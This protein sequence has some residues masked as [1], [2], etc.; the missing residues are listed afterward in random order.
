CFLG[1]GCFEGKSFKTWYLQFFAMMSFTST[2]QILGNNEAI[3]ACTSN[4]YS[5]RV[6]SAEF[7]NVWLNLHLHSSNVQQIKV[8]KLYTTLLKYFKQVFSNG[9]VI[10]SHRNSNYVSSYTFWTSLIIE[11]ETTFAKFGYFT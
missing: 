11:A 6:L 8:A 5:R 4:I 9:K 7:Q 1:L 2:A 10:H 3:A